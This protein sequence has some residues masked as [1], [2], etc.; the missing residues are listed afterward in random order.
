MS[1]SDEDITK[2]I[3]SKEFPCTCTGVIEDPKH[4]CKGC[5]INALKETINIK[6]EMIN[7]LTTKIGCAINVLNQQK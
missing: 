3:L 1:I 4:V 6:Q 2:Y 5:V 7:W